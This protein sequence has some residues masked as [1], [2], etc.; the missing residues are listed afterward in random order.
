ML[1]I[2]ELPEI[3]QK[4]QLIFRCVQIIQ[5]LSLVLVDNACDGFDLYN[6][7][8][9]TNKVRLEALCKRMPFIFQFDDRLRNK[10]NALNSEFDPETFLLH[11]FSK[12]MTFLV[13]Y[14]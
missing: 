9:V 11:R 1:E 12:A 5:G 3:A 14:L 4:R 10:R 2:R 6:N 8:V 7:S 13:I